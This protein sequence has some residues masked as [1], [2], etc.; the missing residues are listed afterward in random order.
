MNQALVAP[1]FSNKAL[2]LAILFVVALALRLI[3]HLLYTPPLIG[4][5]LE[6]YFNS[7]TLENVV[8]M[9]PY[10]HWY[11][12]TPVC[13][14]FLYITN[15][16]LLIQIILSAATCVLLELL[17]RH[18]RWVYAFYLPSIFFSNTYVKEPLLIFLFVTAA[19]LLRNHRSWLLIVLPAIFAGFIS[20][21]DVWRYNA[22]MSMRQN[23]FQKIWIV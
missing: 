15:Q 1:S 19:Y 7:Q 9:F 21:G 13:M 18:A 16:N 12:R 3:F 8:R 2:R 11:E 17:Y 23:F 10:D 4:D 5:A 22:E 14:A 6:Y 20:Y